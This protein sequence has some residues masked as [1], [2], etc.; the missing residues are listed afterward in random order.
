MRH[1][2]VNLNLRQ[3]F[4]IRNLGKFLLCTSVPIIISMLFGL[5]VL[6][7]Y[8]KPLQ[9]QNSQMMVE[10]ASRSIESD[11]Q[12]FNSFAVSSSIMN[13][14][15]TVQHLLSSEQFTYEDLILHSDMKQQLS[16]LRNRSP[17]VKEIAIWLEN[18]N[19]AYLS[20]SGKQLLD[21]NSVWLN[22][23]DEHSQDFS[24]WTVAN[25]SLE[26]NVYVCHRLWSKGIVAISINTEILYQTISSSIP[27]NGE[28]LT[29]M[30]E[31]DDLIVSG[32]ESINT[33]NFIAFETVEKNTGW[34]IRLSVPLH[35]ANKLTIQYIRIMISFLL[36]SLILSFFLALALTKKNTHQISILLDT[37]HNA[38]AGLPLPEIDES[39]N[40][41]TIEYISQRMIASFLEKDY[42]KAQLEAKK[43]K[44]AHAELVAMQAQL[45]PHFLY[46]TLE[47]LNWNCY[48]LTGHPNQATDIIEKLSD[49]LH[50]SLGKNG[51]FVSLKDEIEYI[52][53]YLSLLK[54]RYKEKLQYRFEIDNDAYE[55]MLPRM[56]LQPLVE[57]AVQ[58]GIK[59][60]KGSGLVTIS[61]EVEQGNLILKVEDN[62]VGI[63]DNNLKNIQLI[64]NKQEIRT[65]HIGLGNVNLR[66][67]TIYGTGIIV[68]SEEKKGTIIT[69]SISN[70]DVNNV[71]ADDC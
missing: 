30:S 62:G 65:D 50:Y 29:V 52:D 21:D 26:N 47:T 35:I 57:N 28:F 37:I 36:G 5:I 1:R 58:H 48:Q 3:K 60:K 66:L 42:L 38:E 53:S 14:R 31:N 7:S 34:K 15:V 39:R 61:A 46:N 19:N 13:T 23:L 18:D 56:I 32:E 24:W 59:P 25:N 4:F 27:D 8:L 67:R 45:N 44:A 41:T 63:P 11:F 10:K 33:N 68:E 71:Q 43:Y 2:L 55:Y 51:I 6:H 20:D 40:K 64:L 16:S 12:E 69:V 54:I 9:D 70:K 49:I 22:S 17:Y